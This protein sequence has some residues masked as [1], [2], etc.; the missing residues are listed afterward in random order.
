[1]WQREAV[2]LLTVADLVRGDVPIVRTTDDLA[3]VLQ[4]LSLHDLTRLPVCLPNSPTTVIG[5]ISRAGI[6]R[7]YQRGAA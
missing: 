6:L 4:A 5:L 1:L 3:S 7:R 2:P